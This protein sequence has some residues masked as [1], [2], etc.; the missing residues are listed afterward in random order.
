MLN[1]P[2]CSDTESWEYYNRAHLAI[3]SVNP[4]V[5]VVASP[6][7]AGQVGVPAGRDGVSGYSILYCRR[8]HGVFR[9]GGPQLTRSALLV[10]FVACV[11]A[12]CPT[13]DAADVPL[14]YC[15]PLY[16]ATKY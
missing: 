14:W 16:A 2:T 7:V 5:Y 1:E 6:C 15:R 8:S 3:R 4:R 9:A 11:R 10:G 13:Y 12:S